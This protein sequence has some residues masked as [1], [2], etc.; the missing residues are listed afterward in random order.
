MASKAEITSALNSRILAGEWRIGPDM[1]LK[2]VPKDCPRFG[3]YGGF[4]LL[5]EVPGLYERLARLGPAEAKLVAGFRASLPQ[6]SS[7]NAQ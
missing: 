4:G 6:R 3:D 7:R 1:D 2:D 5:Y